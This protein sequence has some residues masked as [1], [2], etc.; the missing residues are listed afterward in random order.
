MQKYI[1]KVFNQSKETIVNLFQR[2]YFVSVGMVGTGGGAMC[3]GVPLIWI[4]VGHGPILFVV[5]EG[6]SC[7]NI[8]LS[9][10]I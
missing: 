6:G 4:I 5:G 9:P 10:I 3:P 8:F 2:C 7:L 1:L